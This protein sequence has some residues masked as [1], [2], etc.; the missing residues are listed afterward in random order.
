MFTQELNFPVYNR[1]M[2]ITYMACVGY[3]VLWGV[4]KKSLTQRGMGGHHK[5]DIPKEEDIKM[6]SFSARLFFFSE[7]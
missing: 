4:D 2:Q 6:Y 3:R 5:K 1:K 7:V